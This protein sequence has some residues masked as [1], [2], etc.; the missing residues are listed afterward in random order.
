MKPWAIGMCAAL[1]ACTSLGARAEAVDYRVDG[2]IYEGYRHLAA[3]GRPLILLVHDWDG[4]TDY[5]IKRSEMLGKLGYNVFAA[6]LFGKGNRPVDLEAKKRETGTLYQDR[7]KMR[8]LLGS[9]LETARQSLGEGP[10]VVLGYCFGGAAALE[11]A[12]SGADLAGTVSVHGE[13][14]T[15]PG[16]DYRQVKGAVLIQHGSADESVSLTEF[17]A[18]AKALELAGVQH[19]MTSY[20]GAPHAFSVFG[21]ERYRADADAKAWRRLVEWLAEVTASPAR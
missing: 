10:V 11:F 17:A 20:S 14:S 9:A 7:P 3:K 19:E 6:D 12:R 16:Q 2:K 4:L 15:P 1:A 21:S 5:E 18:L 13:L 8:A